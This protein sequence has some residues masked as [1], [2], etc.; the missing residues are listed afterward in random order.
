MKII[1]Y[2]DHRGVEYTPTIIENNSEERFIGL[3]VIGKPGTIHPFFAKRG[4]PLKI[5][6][7]DV[8]EY[9][10]GSIKESESIGNITITL[11]PCDHDKC[12]VS[13]CTKQP[14]KLE[15]PITDAAQY[16]CPEC[17]GKDRP[18]GQRD[19]VVVEADVCR[20]LEHKLLELQSKLKKGDII[21]LDVAT[22]YETLVLQ[23]FR[24][25]EYAQETREKVP[26]FNH[27]TLRQFAIDK[28]KNIEF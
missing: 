5:F 10:G 24:E 22:E 8:V 9:F 7:D 6:L 20:K 19:S 2:T 1:T 26:E 12:P 13:H 14:V 3:Q 15:S 17:G 21:T 11:P 28:M 16:W 25:C 23:H 18:G 27:G 4:V